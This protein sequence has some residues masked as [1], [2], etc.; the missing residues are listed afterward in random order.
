[1]LPIHVVSLPATVHGAPPYGN[2]TLQAAL[3]GLPPV[4]YP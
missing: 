2:E 4:V 1:L 3:E